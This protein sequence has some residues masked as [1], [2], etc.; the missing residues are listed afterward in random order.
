MFT[1]SMVASGSLLACLLAL[2]AFIGTVAARTGAEQALQCSAVGMGKAIVLRARYDSNKVGGRLFFISFR[3]EG[4]FGE[5]R[6]MTLVLA[7]TK[8][9]KF[10]LER[11]LGGDVGAELSLN[12]PYSPGAHVKRFRS[13]F[14]EIVRAGMN[15]A[16]KS[17]PRTIMSCRF[18]DR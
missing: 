13:D 17:G 15:V 7:G 16:L 5:G 12:D 10:K 9:A 1:K 11:M 6:K 8:V 3:A 14:P 2:P 18:E 4:S